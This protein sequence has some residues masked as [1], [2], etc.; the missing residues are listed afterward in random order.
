KREAPQKAF[1]SYTGYGL[2]ALVNAALTAVSA[3]LLISFF[4]IGKAPDKSSG[5]AIA[6]GDYVLVLRYPFVQYVRGDL[7]LLERAFIGRI[8]AIEGD[9]VR[10]SDNIFYIN[11]R[12]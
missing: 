11:D 7:V 10:Y 4:S 3:A 6:P 12:A 9:R 1:N 2:F 5:P 8:I